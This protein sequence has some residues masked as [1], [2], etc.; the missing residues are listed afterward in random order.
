MINS[1]TMQNH[2]T[3]N[4]KRKTNIPNQYVQKKKK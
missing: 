2:H 1:K 4:T 3:E